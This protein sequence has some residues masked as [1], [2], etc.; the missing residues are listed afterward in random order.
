MFSLIFLETETSVASHTLLYWGSNPKPEYVP[1]PE[2]EPTTFWHMGQCSVNWAQILSY[3]V[4]PHKIQTLS[5]KQ[6]TS[7]TCIQRDRIHWKLSSSLMSWGRS[8]YCVPSKIVTQ[9]LVF[10]QS[11][12]MTHRSFTV[13]VKANTFFPKG[14]PDAIRNRT[15]PSVDIPEC[16]YCISLW[17]SPS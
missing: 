9:H 2:I 3:S 6:C 13:S 4:K 8:V 10:L 17:L 7:P 1:W 11:L 15:P 12:R 16:Y 5:F 14:F